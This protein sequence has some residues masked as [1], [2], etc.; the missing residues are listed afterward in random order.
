MKG[1]RIGSLWYDKDHK[2]C[3]GSDTIDLVHLVLSADKET[4]WGQVFYLYK[5]AVFLWS[6]PGYCGAHMRK[7]TEDE[8]RL[9]YEVGN[10]D[11]IFAPKPSIFTPRP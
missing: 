11:L 3:D 7:F 1:I 2:W 6:S 5:T 10:I 8:L 9:M 4:I